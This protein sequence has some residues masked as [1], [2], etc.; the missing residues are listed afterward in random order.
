[1][2]LTVEE[3]RT[4]LAG[5]TLKEVTIDQQ[6]EL[7]IIIDRME[8]VIANDNPCSGGRCSNPAAHA[9]GAHDL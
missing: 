4:I 5:L 8:L 9:E 1:M 2:M 6:G 3:I 7:D